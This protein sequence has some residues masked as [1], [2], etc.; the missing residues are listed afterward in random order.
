MIWVILPVLTFA[1]PQQ[2]EVASIRPASPTSSRDRGHLFD[3]PG[4]VHGESVTMRTVLTR[5]FDVKQNDIDGPAWLDDAK[6]DVNA[7]IPAAA[8]KDQVPAMLRQLLTERFHLATHKENRDMPAYVLTIAKGGIKFKQNHDPNIKPM[9]PGDLGSGGEGARDR[10]GYPIIP[11]HLSGGVGHSTEGVM[12]HTAVAMTMENLLRMIGVQ[13]DRP[14]PRMVDRTGL[15]G[16]YDFK[17][18]YLVTMP[19]QT[20]HEFGGP[21]ITEAVE[22]QLGL[23]VEKMKVP[24][25]MLIVDHI[26]RTPTEN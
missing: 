26:D 2:F 19:G 10:D 18:E 13:L 4:R 22:K 9:H 7:K 21:P 12:K 8:T 16:R 23:H 15:T 25:E 20:Q 5:A 1:P 17:L 24:V 6:F 11:P 14:L 3:D